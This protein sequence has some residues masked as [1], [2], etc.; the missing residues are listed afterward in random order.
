MHNRTLVMIL[1]LAGMIVAGCARSGSGTPISPDGRPGAVPAA[2]ARPA[3]G[4]TLLWGYYDL[5]FD[6]S[7]G[8]IEA[9]LS[10]SAMFTLNATGFLNAA[11]GSLQLTMNGITPGFDYLDV[12]LDVTITHPV[13]IEGFDGY[14]VRGVFIGNGSGKLDSNED[15]RCAVP[16]TDQVLLNADG[17][18]RWFNPV[19]F[20]SPGIFGHVPGDFASNAYNPTATLN[21]YK[22]FGEGLGSGDDLIAYLRS[23]VA[24]TGY[25]LRGT[26]NTRNYILRFPVPSPGVKYAYAVVANWSGKAPSNHPSHAPEAVGCRIKD[27]D[28]VLWY[29]DD[30]N[31]GGRLMLD[32]GVFDW[33]SSPESGVMTEYKIAVESTVTSAPYTLDLSEM[34]PWLSDGQYHV[35]HVEIEADDI[36][37]ANGNEVWV[38]VKYPGMDYSNPLGVPNIADGDAL[39]A[40]FRSDLTVSSFPVRWIRVISPNGGEVWDASS[41][42]TVTWE[43][44]NLFGNVLLECST[45]GFDLHHVGMG[46]AEADDC[47]FIW[48]TP[49]SFNNYQVKVMWANDINVNDI[50]DEKFEVRERGWADNWTDI[51]DGTAWGVDYVI[52]EYRPVVAASEEVGPSDT[53][54]ILRKYDE[55]GVLLWERRWDGDGPD[56]AYS[57]AGSSQYSYVVGTFVGPMDFDPGK[58]EDIKNPVGPQD[59]YLSKFDNSGQYEWAINWGG[60]GAD[61]AAFDVA[62]DGSLARSYVTGY[63]D[64]TADFD[65][66]PGVWSY[67]CLSLAW[68]YLAVY[69]PTGD[70]QWMWGWGGLGGFT[71]STVGYAVALDASGNIYV[72]GYYTDTTDF[73][74]QPGPPDNRTSNGGADAFLMKFDNNGNYKWTRTWGGTGADAGLD[75]RCDSSGNVVVSGNYSQTCDLDPGVGADLRTSNG[76]MDVFVTKFDPSGNYLWSAT[77]GGSNDDRGRGVSPDLTGNVFVTGFFSGTVDFDPGPGETIVESNGSATDAFVSKFD[78]SGA[79]Q[80]VRVPSGSFADQG[81]DIA[82]TFYGSVLVVG[83]FN[84]SVQFAPNEPPCEWAF[85]LRMAHWGSDAFIMKYLGD[86]CW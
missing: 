13:D 62:H 71:G 17:Y 11:P 54:S 83:T 82:T 58:N 44:Y 52:G 61:V 2:T 29:V 34:T 51:G 38:S 79:F 78:P 42:Q 65:P 36:K 46:L 12:D 45:D 8:T 16:G 49:C 47:Q 56:Y 35:Y 4:Q 74:P 39:T 75:A 72:T 19:E 33:G 7:S 10:R 86:G 6:P 14:D 76:M 1:I 26:S 70:L 30:T 80:W 69:G 73:D 9:A 23:G 25:F 3:G 22:Y 50:S 31:R 27:D 59:S 55:C 20:T 64:G 67:S 15:L 66:G 63:F 21:P 68:C 24:N 60:A 18:T 77:W 85:D 28:S 48:D 43:H 32:I 81:Y 41:P 5:M 57:V 53:C 84:S 40:C 37:S